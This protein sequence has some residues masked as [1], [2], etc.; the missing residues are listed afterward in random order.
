M[1]R[2]KSKCSLQ[3]P[4]V[5]ARMAGVAGVN[6]A[7]RTFLNSWKAQKSATLSLESDKG[8]LSVVLKVNFGLYSDSEGRK[9]AGRGYQGLLGRQV[10][11]SQL[12]RRERRA[13]DQAIQQRAAEHAA[14]A[15][16]GDALSPA[17]VE[18]AAPDPA[19]QAAVPPLGC[20]SWTSC[21]SCC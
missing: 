20:Y 11:P 8:D 7:L 21:P 18:Q 19:E 3:T 6:K 14:S 9:E 5:P 4:A 1:P 16:A 2:L 13:A 17:A 15:A 12:R 10:G